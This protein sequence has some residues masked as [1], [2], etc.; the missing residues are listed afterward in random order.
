MLLGCRPLGGDRV[1]SARES[2]SLWI[3]ATEY[4]L[5]GLSAGMLRAIKLMEGRVRLMRDMRGLRTK[6]LPRSVQ[7]STVGV[8]GMDRLSVLS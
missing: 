2:C 8:A 4:L 6:L 1:A 3:P 5:G 7:M